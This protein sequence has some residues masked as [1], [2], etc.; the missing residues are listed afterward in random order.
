MQ[1]PNEYWDIWNKKS[2]VVTI[3]WY[4]SYTN[5]YANIILIKMHSSRMCTT[6]FGG[7]YLS[8]LGLGGGGGCFRPLS[9][10]PPPPFIETPRRNMGPGIEA[11]TK[12][13]FSLNLSRVPVWWGDIQVIKVNYVWFGVCVCVL[14]RVD[15]HDW[16][17]YLPASSLA[18]GNNK[19]RT[20][21]KDWEIVFS[22]KQ[23]CCSWTFW[24]ESS[25]HHMSACTVIN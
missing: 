23:L 1:K 19:F 2:K 5:E 25:V 11:V 10:W 21:C 7:H 3:V 14:G 18:G 6:H 22:I 15:S 17:H 24:L 13:P 20:K 12:R 8:V 4:L 16:K 9:Q